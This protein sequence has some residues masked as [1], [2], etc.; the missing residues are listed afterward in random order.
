MALSKVSLGAK[1]SSYIRKSVKAIVEKL[2]ETSVTNALD[3]KVEWTKQIEDVEDT[4]DIQEF[5]VATRKK[6]CVV[7]DKC[8]HGLPVTIVSKNIKCLLVI[9]TI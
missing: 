6:N 2:M 5:K 4:D 3:K 1:Q 9:K 8:I 7:S